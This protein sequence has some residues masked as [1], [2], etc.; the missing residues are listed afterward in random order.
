MK[1]NQLGRTGIKVS[2]ICLGSMT[3]GEQNSEQDGHRQMDMA[4]EH[5]VNFIDTAERYAFPGKKETCGRSEEIIGSWLKKQGNRDRMVIATKITGPGLGCEYI[6]GGDH[7]FTRGNITSAIESSLKRLNTDVIDLYQTHWPD[8]Q[9]NKFGQLDFPY[10]KEEG[11]WVALQELL[12]IMQQQI[13]AGNIRA[14]GVSNESAWGVMK[15]LSLSENRGLPRVASI[16]NAYSL[17]TRQ[18]EVGLSEV[19]LREDCG[20][21]AYS[22][23]AFGVLS[24]KYLDGKKPE[25]ARLQRF[26][27]FK[28]YLNDNALSAALKYRE[29][30]IAHGIDS[31]QM[32]IAYVTNRPFATSTII[33]ATTL[34]Q[35]ESN[36]TSESLEL[37]DEV[38]SGID[39]LH[40]EHSNP[41]P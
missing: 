27:A 12:E 34:K 11:K 17:T 16:Q 37:S 20:L 25:G 33:G 15:M 3:F 40:R 14:Y 39:A 24:G 19:A 41:A 2:R 4:V 32:A 23:L 35:L 9:V 21:L 30:A 6:R 26:P 22:P 7:R 18:F 28:R 10:A 13:Q 38:I 36:L 31:S 8:R 1:Y 5:G 29:L